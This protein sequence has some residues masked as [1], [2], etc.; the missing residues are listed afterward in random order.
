MQD[1]LLTPMFTGSLIRLTG[2]RPE[3]A[4]VFARWYENSDFS[5]L[6]DYAPAYPRSER[7]VSQYFNETEENRSTSFPFAIRPLY[8]DEFIGYIDIDGIMWNHRTGWMSIAIGEP[9]N[10]GRGYGREAMML[11]LKFAFHELNLHRLQLTVF[12]YNTSAI[13]L[14]ESLGFVREGVQREALH[15]EGERYDMLLYGIL[16]REWEAKQRTISS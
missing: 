3:D 9:V 13:H 16:A 5:R 6:Y 4:R 10:R 7:R 12:S 14:Y 1:T 11:V 15:R 2:L 8:S